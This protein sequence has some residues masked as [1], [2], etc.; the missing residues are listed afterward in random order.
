[1]DMPFVALGLLSPAGPGRHGP[2]LQ[3]CPWASKENPTAS[4]RPI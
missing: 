4:L 1:M 2:I 3:F